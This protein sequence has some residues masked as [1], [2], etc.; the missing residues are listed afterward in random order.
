MTAMDIRTS[1]NNELAGFTPDMLRVVD[2][3]VKSLRLKQIKEFGEPVTD[4]LG[5][6]ERAY[7]T[8][9][10]DRDLADIAEG[11][12]AEYVSGDEFWNHFEQAV[13]KRYEDIPAD[14]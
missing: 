5:D 7:W 4:A 3:F 1:I 2:A 9:S 14:V 10:V 13:T 6:E 12:P 8:Q 11:K